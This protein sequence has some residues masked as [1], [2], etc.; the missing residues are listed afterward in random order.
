MQQNQKT[1][2]T[3]RDLEEKIQKIYKY[4]LILESKLKK[5]QQNEKTLR[6]QIDYLKD[7]IRYFFP[8]FP[9]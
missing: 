2:D 3:N 9:L 6:T 8:Q 7:Q 5:S 1:K 4:S